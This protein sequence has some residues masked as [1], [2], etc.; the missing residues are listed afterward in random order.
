MKEPRSLIFF[1]GVKYKITYNKEGKFNQSLLAL[2]ID[3]PA[4]ADLD[5][6]SKIK[7][8]IA[9]PGI[10]DIDYDTTNSIEFH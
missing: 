6:W 3:V 4:Y 1:P 7:I 5:L 2:L 9:P 10:K 8:L